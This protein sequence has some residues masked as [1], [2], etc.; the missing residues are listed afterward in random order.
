MDLCL[1]TCFPNDWLYG[2]RGTTVRK[3]SDY[4]LFATTRPEP[5]NERIGLS[6]PTEPNP[7]V[8]AIIYGFSYFC[9]F[10]EFGP[11]ATTFIY[12]QRFFL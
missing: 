1:R 2:S 3:Q 11:N 9:F 5:A 12:P 10:T 7:P 6:A 4:F 8:D